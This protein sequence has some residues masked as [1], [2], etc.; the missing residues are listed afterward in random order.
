MPK[1]VSLHDRATRDLHAA[2]WGDTRDATGR[3]VERAVIYAEYLQADAQAVQA[4]LLSGAK[5]DPAALQKAAQT[6]DTADL[7]FS[8]DGAEK[9]DHY[10]FQ[11][12]CVEMTDEDGSRLPIEDE[13]TF[14]SMLQRDA[15]Y[16]M[17]EIRKLTQPLVQPSEMDAEMAS[18]SKGKSAQAMAQ[19]NF[20]PRRQAA[21][22]Q[23]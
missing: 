11:Q 17:G 23:R 21:G 2:W 4:R 15:E 8:L 14:T 20:R 9:Q 19:D 1:L 3:Y 12:V 5:F 18:A 22:A 13:E 10:L 6:R 7:G 16:I